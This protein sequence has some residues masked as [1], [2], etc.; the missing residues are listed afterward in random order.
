MEWGRRKNN[1]G[2]ES[3]RGLTHVCIEM[4]QWTPTCYYSHSNNKMFSEKRRMG[5]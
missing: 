1:G 3:I 5:T 4:S 2:D